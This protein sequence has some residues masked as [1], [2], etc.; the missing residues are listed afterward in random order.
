MILTSEN[1]HTGVTRNLCFKSRNIIAILCSDANEFLRFI[2][3][4]IPYEYES[5]LLE[6]MKS[7]DSVFD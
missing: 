5:N 3:D 4:F 1:K 6:K 7:I 2:F